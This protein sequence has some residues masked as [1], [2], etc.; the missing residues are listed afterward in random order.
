MKEISN[1]DI[2]IIII[3]PVALECKKWIDKEFQEARRRQRT[4]IPCKY[5]KVT[6]EQMKVIEGLTKCIM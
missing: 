4:I 2:F 6:R 1:R 5:H 3:T